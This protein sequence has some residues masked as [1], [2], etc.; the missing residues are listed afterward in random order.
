MP[1]VLQAV[2][3][4][5]EEPR[6][7]KFTRENCKFLEENGL[8]EGRYELIEGDILFKMPQKMPHI[9]F[10]ISIARWLI[11]ALGHEYVLEQAPISIP[12]PDSKT[13]E[14]EPDIVVTSEN[15]L[16]M[17]KAPTFANVLLLVE[18]SDTT[19][20][21]DKN[22]KAALYA[23]AGFREYWIADVN[24][25]QIIVHREPTPTGYTDIKAYSVGETVSL[26]ARPDLSKS[27]EE[28]IPEQEEETD[29]N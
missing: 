15:I 11:E 19:L 24:A 12:E 3:Y 10:L 8:L 21:T 22:R 6:R 18:V 1:T 14:P 2:P 28:L 20:Y 16:R 7:M 5:S 9:Q 23:R 26:L 13:N 27:V 29:E 4:Q 17:R 25:R